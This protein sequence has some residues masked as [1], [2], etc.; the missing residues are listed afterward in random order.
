MDAVILIMMALLA[1]VVLW[2]V[3]SQRQYQRVD[4]GAMVDQE[5][6]ERQLGRRMEHLDRLIGDLIAY[7]RER[8]EELDALVATTRAELE[9][10]VQQAK[11]EIVRDV[12]SQGQTFDE[13]LLSQ[14]GV[15][16][17]QPQPA[18]GGAAEPG[19]NA[20]LVR[21]FKN[22]RQHQIAELL[23]LGHTPAEVSRFLGVSQHEVD[24]VGS[25]IF[26]ESA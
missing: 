16:P 20:N 3:L 1:G 5:E 21:F 9:Q 10:Q 8:R 25:I 12:L 19:A 24:L 22:P 4:Y 11:A 13:L 7:E 18:R 2:L 15:L 14:Q 26:S 6:R 23:E 17:G